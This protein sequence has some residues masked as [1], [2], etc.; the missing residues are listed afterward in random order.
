MKANIV[1]VNTTDEYIALQP[2]EFRAGLNELRSVILSVV[3]QAM[4]SISYQVPC[5]KYHYMLVGI[6]VNKNS[7]SFYTMSP[8]L[9]KELK[10]DLKG[11]KTSGATLHFTPSEP[12]PMELIKKIVQIRAQQNELM[13]LSKKQSLS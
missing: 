7:V 8:P 9:V 3:P 11:I 10:E 2:E 1:Q 5:F 13:A 12:L 6:G 4:E